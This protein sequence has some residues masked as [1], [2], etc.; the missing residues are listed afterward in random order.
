MKLEFEYFRLKVLSSFDYV[1][2][3]SEEEREREW[4]AFNLIHYSEHIFRT[5][6]NENESSDDS[7]HF[8][9]H[10]WHMKWNHVLPFHWREQISDGERIQSKQRNGNIFLRCSDNA[11]R[12]IELCQWHFISAV[13]RASITLT[14]AN[15][16]YLQHN[17]RPQSGKENTSIS[18]RD[19]HQKISLSKH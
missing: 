10:L 17:A 1:N 14:K 2:L 5:F 19:R 3:F 13:D 8:N 18:S 12:R 4:G 6:V 16:F 9:K 15:R 11:T 7:L